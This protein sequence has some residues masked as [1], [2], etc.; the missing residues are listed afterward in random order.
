MSIYSTRV[1]LG[2]DDFFVETGPGIV[3]QYSA[4]HIYP[5]TET[6]EQT[7]LETA[8]IPH[9]C[10]PGGYDLDDEDHLLYAPWMRLSLDGVNVILDK[11]AVKLLKDDLEEWLSHFH[12]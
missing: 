5:D 4:S 2:D 11:E 9:F 6:H 8:H 7:S 10:M 3:L 12:G 1:I